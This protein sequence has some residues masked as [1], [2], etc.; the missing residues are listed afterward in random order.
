MKWNGVQ[1]TCRKVIEAKHLWNCGA[2]RFRLHVN[3]RCPAMH[4]GLRPTTV[5]QLG[6]STLSR[7]YRR[8][9]PVHLHLLPK[10]VKT[11]VGRSCSTCLASCC[12]VP[13][14]SSYLGNWACDDAPPTDFP[15]TSFLFAQMAA[16]WKRVN[17]SKPESSKYCLQ[18][19]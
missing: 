12:S 3:L 5:A 15:K 8:V 16:Q 10:V 14:L 17:A 19:R 1:H 13:S 11:T 9:G 2:C 7:R 6:I 4:S 18:C